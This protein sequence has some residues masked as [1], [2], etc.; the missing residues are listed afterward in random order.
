MGITK[1]SVTFLFLLILAAFVSNYNVLASGMFLVIYMLLYSKYVSSFE[2]K[3]I[4]M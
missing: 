3:N 2:S 1:T 4:D